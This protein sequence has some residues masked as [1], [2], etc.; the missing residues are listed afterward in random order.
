MKKVINL[1]N[2]EYLFLSNFANSTVTYEGVEYPTVEHAFQAA[3]TLDKKERK[4]IAKAETPGKAKKM[5]RAVKLREDWERIKEQVMYE[6]VKEKFKDPVLKKKLEETYPI[7]LIEGNN[8]HDNCWGDCSC[9]KCKEKEGKNLLGNILMRVRE[10]NM[11]EQTTSVNK[12]LIVVDMQND[13]IDGVLGT[14]EAV[15]IVPNVKRKIDEYVSNGDEVIFT[16]D[17]HYG[18]YLETQEG[19]KLPV[20]H[21]IFGTDGWEVSKEIDIPDALHLYK[22]TFGTFQFKSGLTKG[23]KY[24]VIEV[25]GVCTDICVISNCMILKA[26]FP[27]TEIVIDASCCAGVKPE[28]HENALKAMECCQIT[29]INK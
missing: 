16:Q 17:T 12:A 20:P 3:K 8:W 29:I 1:F 9:E 11:K 28:F 19:K 23:K 21:C 5:G 26:L 14:P 24:D 7:T 22:E 15:A 27:E 18:N 10:E 2:G 25:I 4:K 13:F 6:C